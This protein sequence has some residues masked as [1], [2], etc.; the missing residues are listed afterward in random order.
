MLVY[1]LLLLLYLNRL[2]WHLYRFLST[3]KNHQTFLGAMGE[4]KKRSSA[5]KLFNNWFFFVFI[6]I[7]IYAWRVFLFKSKKYLFQIPLLYNYID[8]R[9]GFL[10]LISIAQIPNKFFQNLMKP[11]QCY[12]NYYTSFYASIFSIYI[13]V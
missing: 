13:F 5:P 4:W 7:Y 9:L 6:C 11:L 8:D 2:F 12:T 3:I 1:Y 10:V